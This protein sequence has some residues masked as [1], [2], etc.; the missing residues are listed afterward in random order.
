MQSLYGHS[1]EDLENLQQVHDPPSLLYIEV[2]C[3]HFPP[4]NH[5]ALFITHKIPLFCFVQLC[6][7]WWLKKLSV[8][9]L[10]LFLPLKFGRSINVLSSDS[11]PAA[12][13]QLSVAPKHTPPIFSV[14]KQWKL[15]TGSWSS[16]FIIYRSILHTFSPKKPQCIVY[17][18]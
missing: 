15:T 3:I 11:T 14:L 1:P 6:L 13:F 2:Y 7:T 16:K 17:Y 4:R 9:P 5:N 10:H 12:M 8:L 18:T